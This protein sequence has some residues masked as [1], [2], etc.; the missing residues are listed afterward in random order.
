MFLLSVNGLKTW[1]GN[2]KW[3][4]RKSTTVE[5]FLRSSQSKQARKKKKKLNQKAFVF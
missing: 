5:H 2:W 3:K 4:I 1:T